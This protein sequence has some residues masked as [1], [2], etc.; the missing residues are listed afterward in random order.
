[1]QKNIQ[2]VPLKKEW[3]NG[4]AF[5]GM[6]YNNAMNDYPWA[7]YESNRIKIDEINEKLSDIQS[8]LRDYFG[9]SSFESEWLSNFLTRD[10]LLLGGLKYLF[11][12]AKCECCNHYLGPN[13]IQRR[14]YKISVI[15][16]F[17][18]RHYGKVT[19]DFKCS[20][21]R[22]QYLFVQILESKAKKLGNY[23]FPPSPDMMMLGLDRPSIYKKTHTRIPELWEYQ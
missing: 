16:G 21:I 6:E 11:K 1:M 12:Y 5:Q 23:S 15:N 19:P 3:P 2:I 9:S 22:L 14:L 10:F 20:A 7:V 17:C 18:E 13:S 8:E 4:R